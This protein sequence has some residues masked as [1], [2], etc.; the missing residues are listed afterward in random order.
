[1]KII[2]FHELELLIDP[3]TLMYVRWTYLCMVGYHKKQVYKTNGGDQIQMC[4]VVAY[5]Q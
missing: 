1:M 4:V 5:E 2:N 3:S